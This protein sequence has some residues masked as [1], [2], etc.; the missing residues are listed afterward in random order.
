MGIRRQALKKFYRYKIV[1]GDNYLLPLSDSVFWTL[2]L[3]ILPES[4]SVREK[5]KFRLCI[6]GKDIDSFVKSV[7]NIF[8]RS[9]DEDYEKRYNLFCI[10]VFLK[11]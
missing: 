9:V 11:F 10:L 6:E 3:A 7:G 8:A 2:Y 5:I 4:S 1:V